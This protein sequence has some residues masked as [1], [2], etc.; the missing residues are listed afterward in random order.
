MTNNFENFPVYIKSLDLIEKVYS[1]LQS[2]NFEK[3]FEFNNQIKRASFSI[4]NN[5]AE[6]SEYNNNRQ[7]IRYLKIAKGSC[8]EVR[9]MLIVS[10]RLKLGDQNKA[11]EIITLSREI[12][13]NI[14]N[15]I[16]Y[17][18]ENIEKPNL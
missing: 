3:E 9:S 4:S 18:S 8:A 7:F 6:G 5:I 14:S 16:K 13:S 11:E 15:F 10:R 2:Q 12:S 1:F 17:L